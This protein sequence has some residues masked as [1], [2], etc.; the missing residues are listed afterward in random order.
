M[1]TTK[2]NHCVDCGALIWNASTRCTRCAGYARWDAMGR[3]QY[4]CLDCGGPIS[5]K[6]K[7]CKSC[8]VTQVWGRPEHKSKAAQAMSDAWNEERRQRFSGAG[9][10]NWHDGANL[11]PYGAEW[12]NGLKEY[13]RQRDGYIC[14]LC[15]EQENGR[16]HD[17]H[18]INYVKIDNRP[19]NLVT[20]CK[21]CHGQT[22]YDRDYWIAELET[23][24]LQ[25]D[26]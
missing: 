24:R 4:R 17:V 23:R 25:D 7:R 15:G 14:Q 10:N 21:S 18:H 22:N 6:A 8:A 12:N 13:V 20:L 1:P 19:E 11:I 5:R 3:C 16:S 26:F 9:N 2:D